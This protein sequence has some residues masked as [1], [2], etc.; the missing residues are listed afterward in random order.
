MKKL[1]LE[2]GDLLFVRTNATRENTG[3]CAVFKNEIPEALFASYLIRLR[4]KPDTLMP[5]FVRE[6]TNS[7]SGKSFLSGRASPAA[8][9]KFNI[10]TQTIRGVLIPC[11]PLDEQ[12]LIMCA[13][14]ACDRKIEAL[15]GELSVLQ[16]LYS[17]VLADLFSQRLSAE[18]LI[19]A[20][21]VT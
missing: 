8:D 14:D 20:G 6:Y 18:Q 16:E 17:S 4:L 19:M 13:L 5:D 11:P 21:A 7:A 15:V 12:R 2:E 1:K 3:K 10:N 9:G